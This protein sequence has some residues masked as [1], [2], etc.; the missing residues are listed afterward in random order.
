MQNWM[1]STGEQK[2]SMNPPA[3]RHRQVS[4]CVAGIGVF[5]EPACLQ[6]WAIRSWA[7][8]INCWGS[9]WPWILQG[10]FLNV[11]SQPL[12]I[13]LLAF[14]ASLVAQH[15]SQTVPA[16]SSTFKGTWQ[17][18]A[19]MWVGSEATYKAT[20][21]TFG[22]QAQ[23]P[24]GVVRTVRKQCSACKAQPSCLGHMAGMPAICTAPLLMGA[25]LL[26]AQREG[27]LCS[28]AVLCPHLF[29]PAGRR[30]MLCAKQC[31]Q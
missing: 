22:R 28:W 18:R 31:N 23:L 16:I 26:P 8:D 3:V 27:Y 11:L 4:D 24:A 1:A 6:S 15:L 7:A 10:W 21:K 29:V 5:L 12:T 19:M 17:Q 25:G 14:I 2:A 20:C 30:V 9:H 13:L